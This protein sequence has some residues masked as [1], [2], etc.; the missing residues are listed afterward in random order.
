MKI[1][2][3]LFVVLSI[4]S[5]MTA[6]SNG[7]QSKEI[8]VTGQLNQSCPIA[9]NCDE[10]FEYHA[11]S[12]DIDSLNLYFSFNPSIVKD[13]SNENIL[14]AFTYMYFNFSFPS[15][16]TDSSTFYVTSPAL[17]G[18][19]NSASS[20]KNEVTKCENG[21]LY[22]RISFPVQQLIER[23][24]SRSEDC[25]AGDISG[26]CYRTRD[27]SSQINYIINYELELH[28]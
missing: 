7:P 11:Y 24:E 3:A 18:R 14:A 20:F 28:D 5:C 19:A 21:R 23:I 1:Y 9:V 16:E 26:I 10:N 22:G 27:L 17:F 13:K 25:H 15:L 6:S 12:G 8:L 2:A 4:T